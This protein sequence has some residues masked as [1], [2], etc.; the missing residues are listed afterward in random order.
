MKRDDKYLAFYE[1]EGQQIYF[2]YFSSA[3]LGETKCVY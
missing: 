3:I 1:V 2:V